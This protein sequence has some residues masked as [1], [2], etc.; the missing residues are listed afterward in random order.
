MTKK[1]EYC[2]FFVSYIKLMPSQS[3][4]QSI[5]MKKPKFSAFIVAFIKIKAKSKYMPS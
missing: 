2:F 4:C 3:T 1:M 5:D